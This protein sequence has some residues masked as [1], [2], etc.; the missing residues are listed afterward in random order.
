VAG[1]TTSPTGW[2][3]ARFSVPALV[4]I[5]YATAALHFPYTPDET[6]ASVRV[7]HTVLTTGS[8]P[9]SATPG[10]PLVLLAAAG[11]ALKLDPILVSKVF[12]LLSSSIALLL[13]Y[14]LAVEVAGDRIFALCATVVITS[15][16]WLLRW[17][18]SGSG[19]GLFFLL[20]ITALFFLQRNEYLLAV[21]CVAAAS[22]MAWY[23]AG[24][25]VGIV[26][27]VLINS[28]DRRRGIMV[29]FASTMVFL[30]MILP[31]VLYATWAGLP[32]VTGTQPLATGLGGSAAAMA[33]L[34]AAGVLALGLLLREPDSATG[35]NPLLQIVGLLWTTGWS[36]AVGIVWDG[37]ALSMA[38]VILVILGFAGLARMLRRLS[39][40][41]PTYGPAVLAAAGLL[42]VTQVEFL[43]VTR[44]EMERTVADNDELTSI[45]YWIRSGVPEGASLAA[46]RPGFLSYVLNRE[47]GGPSRGE[48]PEY[49]VSAADDLPGYEMVYRPAPELPSAD[50]GKHFKI[51]RRL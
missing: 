5:F 18:A 34:A 4:L 44:P 32:V 38:L 50:D 51:W 41:Q 49:L 30:V 46:E 28:R 20:V 12:S 1:L 45:A 7:T 6:F 19:M 3:L 25:M 27:D 37:G 40:D 31:W 36:I 43:T 10:L 17:A 13:V 47:I 48:W 15:Q 24:I 23:A 33:S 22:L 26:A 29:A 16:A 9:V 21:V 35:R 42:L 39:G 14:L 11:R 8:S 2:L